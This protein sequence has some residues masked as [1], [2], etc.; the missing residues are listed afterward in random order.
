M[1]FLVRSQI[2]IH[3]R[4]SMQKTLF[5]RALILLK[6]RILVKILDLSHSFRVHILKSPNFFG[7]GFRENS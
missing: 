5:F 1:S 4:V 3:F 6:F 2:R 7:H